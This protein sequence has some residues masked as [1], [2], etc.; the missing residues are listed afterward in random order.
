MRWCGNAVSGMSTA[1][2][3]HMCVPSRGAT[4]LSAR[5]RVS[6]CAL[7]ATVQLPCWPLARW[8]TA[9]LP[10][11]PRLVSMR[12]DPNQHLDTAALQ[13][14]VDRLKALAIAPSGEQ[15]LPYDGYA[16]PNASSRVCVARAG[17]AFGDAGLGCQWHENVIVTKRLRRQVGSPQRRCIW[18]APWRLDRGQDAQIHEWR[19]LRGTGRAFDPG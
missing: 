16:Q 8:T 7:I 5:Y 3:T 4:C 19:R 1:D 13:A 17:R 12:E 6:S 18:T 11:Q 10:R 9:A 14:E 2:P 15:Q